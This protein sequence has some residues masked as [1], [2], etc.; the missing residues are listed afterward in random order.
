MAVGFLDTYITMLKFLRRIRQNLISQGKFSKYLL[1]ALGEILLVVIGIL[2]ALQI[3]NWNEEKK[4]E[5]QEIKLLRQLKEDLTENNKALNELRE[6]IT[7]N[8]TAMDTVVRRLRERDYENSFDINATLIHRKTYF[9]YANSGYKLIGNG[10]A[11]LISNDSILKGVLL[12]YEKDFVAITSREDLM[13][14]TIDNKVYP[15]TNKLFKIK[16]LRIKF[17]A[18]DAAVSDIYSPLEFNSLCDNQ[19]YINTLFQLKRIFEERLTRIDQTSLDI[20]K[21]IQLLEKE[22]KLKIND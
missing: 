21:V 17:K 2:I 19:E 11:T 14:S 12:L 9:N 13:N 6:R 3:N 18:L 15:F 8:S 1:Y 16:P 22:I 4:Q 10:L 20:S 7:I 5:A